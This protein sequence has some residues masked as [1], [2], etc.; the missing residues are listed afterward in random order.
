M[1]KLGIAILVIV[2]LVVLAA[3]ILPRFLDVNRYRGQIQAQLEQRLGRPVSLGNMSLSLLPPS[4][5][6]DN[7]VIGEDPTFKTGK[8][9]AY[10]QQLYVLMELIPLL[11]REFEISS[12]QLQ[13]PQVEL[14]RGTDGRWN[15]ASLGKPAPQPGAQ[16]QQTAP[17]QAA[18]KQQAAPQPGEQQKFEL[19]ELTIKD[20]QMAITDLQ[21]R[22]PRAVYD[23]I[24][25]TLRDYAPD[26]AFK[27]TAAAHLPGT[28]AQLAK[29][30]GTGG[31]ID[32][33]TPMN[34][35]FDGELNLDEVSISGLQKFLNSQA[36]AGTDAT[37]SGS[38]TVKNENGRMAS[39]G[40]LK[41]DNPVVRGINI[42]YPITADYD[43][44]ND[45]KSE[46]LQINKA[47]VKLGN[48]PLDIS[49]SMNTAPTPALVDMQ[50]K[51]GGVSLGEAAR[52]ASAFGVAFNPNMQVAGKLNADIHAKGP[53]STPALNGNL[54]ARDVNISG[55]D[56]PQPIRVPSID[57]ALTPDAIRSNE[58]TA[59]TGGT[60][61]TM[62]FNLLQY[63]SKS[64]NVD[65][66][67]RTHN[68]N[69]GELLSIAQAY[70]VTAADGMSG[71]GIIS[72][73]VRA[74]GP[75]KNSS[76]MNFSG[77]GA[78]QNAVLN[79]PNLKKP[80]NV[81]NV[82]L[83]F[84]QNSM[85]MQNLAASLGSMNATGN[86]TMRNFAAPQVQFGLNLDKLNVL[87]LQQI[88]P[89]EQ[90]QQPARAGLSI[91]PSAHAAAPNEPSMLS[92][93]TGGGKVSIGTLTYDQLVLNNVNSN[94]V[95][96]R[97]VIRLAPVTA[98]VYGGQETGTIVVDTRGPQT[99]YNVDLR[100]QKVDS[101][102]LL[103]SVSSIKE[104]LYG[105]LAAN[106]QASFTSVP[107]GS[108]IARTLNGRLSL[109]L[110]DGRLANVDMVQQLSAIGKFQNLG[111]TA[112]N[113]TKLQQL[114]GDFDIRN[115]VATT[116][117]MKALIE[118]GTVAATGAVN[119]AAQTIDMRMTAVLSKTYSQQVG[120]T[121]VGGF[122]Q[123]ALANNRGELVLP[124]LV[125]GSLQSPKF[126]PDLNALAQMKLQNVLPS[127]SNPGELTT[128]ILGEVLG[129]KGNNQGGGFGGIVDAITGK[130]KPN[131]QYPQQQ[132]PAA[133]AQQGNQ[134]NQPQQTQTQR[135]REQ[136]QQPK[137]ADAVNDLVDSIFG[138]SKK[139]QEQ[140]QQQPAPQQDPP[141]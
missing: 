117:N 124:V 126:A 41:L 105:L 23:H 8:P 111:R 84:T 57:L 18:P 52:L 115:G 136:Q 138:G 91:I 103:S 93:M 27:I 107:N 42:G 129:N 131:E 83:Q 123:T 119:L 128:G 10:A 97:G 45:L 64:P 106:T 87:E 7:V 6:I 50:V 72:L 92:K 25:L 4:V 38:A 101:N 34:T 28:G 35:P 60:A 85:M 137:A 109:N 81:R 65:A 36:L 121:N 44:S 62:R 79:T 112:Q 3:A 94:V 9:F 77:S 110:A 59:T 98:A 134:P 1:R 53:T 67:I 113:F 99:V 95:L 30:D 32:Q 74:T 69:V 102:K 24:D 127:F 51:A 80:L 118:G 78:V 26:K 37:V 31:P 2:V 13:R 46:I 122:M 132:P 14:V 33:N 90:E 66:T 56:V 114:S 73:D 63:T 29:I 55:K 135:Q 116:N 86:A 58:F 22:T 48:T 120:G 125:T 100:L 61:L 88:L 15:F 43:V 70:G 5:R 20:G 140:Q 82:N 12:L 21:K 47:Q 68:A 130:Q 11:R 96:D 76:A 19:A 49:G 17:P 89:A 16:G 141:R 139:K 40:S 71:S 108:D 39:S 75:V 54:R 133:G 104:T